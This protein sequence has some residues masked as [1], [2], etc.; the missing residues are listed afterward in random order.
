[1]DEVSKPG[2]KPYKW[3]KAPFGHPYAT[4]RGFIQEHRLVAEEI[5]QRCLN[6]EEVVHHID[7]DTM[8]NNISNLMVFAT[9]NEHNSF[10]LG[11]SAWSN[12]G[13]IWHSSKVIH[14]KRCQYCGKLY[15]TKEKSYKKISNS[16]YCSKSCVD[17]SNYAKNIER[18]PEIIKLIKENN[19]NFSAA[20]RV[21]GIT[22]SGLAK[23]LKSHNEKYHSKDYKNIS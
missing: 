12:D 23:L 9:A 3:V 5:V 19:G 13:V 15:V 22:S 17:K 7:G 20:A 18:I 10:H 21:L 1:V 4:K 6:S 16:K 11:A 8:N 2:C 14:V